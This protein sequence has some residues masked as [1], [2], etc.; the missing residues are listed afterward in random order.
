VSY[1]FVMDGVASFVILRY[2]DDMIDIQD[3]VNIIHCVSNNETFYLSVSLA[4]VDRF[5]KFFYCQILTEILCVNVIKIF[6][7]HLKCIYILPR[8]A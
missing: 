3:T 8:E 7:P 5:F 2:R 6:P 4:N 1:Y